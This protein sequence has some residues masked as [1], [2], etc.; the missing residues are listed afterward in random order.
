M[1]QSLLHIKLL[2]VTHV[3]NEIISSYI[4]IFL[5]ETPPHGSPALLLMFVVSHQRALLAGVSV[6]I[7]WE[8]PYIYCVAIH[9]YNRPD[10]DDV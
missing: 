8:W 4:Y 10:V 2:K 3:K 9:M 7:Y 5:W 6:Y 1:K